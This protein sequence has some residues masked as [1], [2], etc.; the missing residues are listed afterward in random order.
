MPPGRGPLNYTTQIGVKQTISECQEILARA[1]AR[2]AEIR[3]EEGRPAGLGFTLK[4]PH[5]IRNFTLPV[6]AGAMHAVL[7]KAGE[8]RLLGR[9]RA[10]YTTREHAA[11]VAWRVLKD[12][13]E[14]QLAL[15]DAQMATLPQIMLPYLHV[16]DE[17]T[18][19]QAYTEH[20]RAALTGGSGE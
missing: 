9:S 14:A 6:N 7:V 8:E 10:A 20:E 16:D 1:G 17:R 15:I 18:L 5:G 3:F 2:S 11:R 4:T 13:L 19:W 12:W